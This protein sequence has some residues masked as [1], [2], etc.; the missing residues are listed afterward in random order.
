MTFVG[1]SGFLFFLYVVNDFNPLQK[2]LRLDLNTL[3]ISLVFILIA[4]ITGRLL[5]LLSNIIHLLAEM[6][7]SLFAF[8]FSDASHKARW[9]AFK[10]N[11]KVSSWRNKQILQ[12]INGSK[13]RPDVSPSSMKNTLTIVDMADLASKYPSIDNRVERDVLQSIFL[14]ILIGSFV[15]FS[16]LISPYFLIPL[17]FAI[18]LEHDVIDDI[19]GADYALY[20]AAVKNEATKGP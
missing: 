7:S 15:V 12:F 13:V 20:C 2:F 6:L 8:I 5:L 4:Y 19:A 3:E 10:Q 11:I 1:G 18:W 16:Y 9:I 17:I 14:R